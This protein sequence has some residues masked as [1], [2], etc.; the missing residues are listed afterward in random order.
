MHTRIVFGATCTAAL[1]SSFSTQAQT[2]VQ[3]N[4][5]VFA[6]NGAIEEVVVTA[7]RRP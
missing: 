6:P 5:S 3:A 4:G 7:R 1:L 2:A